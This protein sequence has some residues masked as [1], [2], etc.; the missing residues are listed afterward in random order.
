MKSHKIQSVVTNH[1]NNFAIY[2]PILYY[3]RN[4]LDIP[5]DTPQL[6]ERTFVS[7]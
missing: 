5:L 3:Y 7:S 4:K 6:Q 1:L 2:I